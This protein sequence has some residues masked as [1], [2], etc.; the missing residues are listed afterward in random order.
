MAERVLARLHARKVTEPLCD[1]RCCQVPSTDDLVPHPWP[2]AV[3]DQT[4]SL[5]LKDSSRVSAGEVW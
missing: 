1:A 2:V 3:R 5:G 4:C